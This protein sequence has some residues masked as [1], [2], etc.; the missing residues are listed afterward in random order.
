MHLA[1][2]STIDELF[3]LDADLA[4]RDRLAVCARHITG[5]ACVPMVEVMSQMRIAASSRAY[6]AALEYATANEP[7]NS[8]YTDDDDLQQGAV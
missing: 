6:D 3:Q 7:H 8:D 4:K 1:E 5:F 2:L